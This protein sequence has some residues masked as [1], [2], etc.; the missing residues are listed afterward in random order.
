MAKSSASVWEPKPYDPT[1]IMCAAKRAFP[2]ETWLSE[3]LSRCT[4]AVIESPAYIYFVNPSLPNQPGSDWQFETNISFIDPDEGLLV[5]D[6]LKES[7]PGEGGSGELNL[8]QSSDLKVILSGQSD[9]ID[10]TFFRSR[11]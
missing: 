2:S 9:R 7:R 4:Q 1:W 11:T 5:L 6:I 3:A 10:G 8:L